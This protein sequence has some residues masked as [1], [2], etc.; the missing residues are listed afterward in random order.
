MKKYLNDNY[1]INNL[2][3]H[4]ICD[5][6]SHKY[7]YHNT[8]D[9]LEKISGSSTKQPIDPCYDILTYF[10]NSLNK[11]KDNISNITDI[12]KYNDNVY[13]IE[14]NGG[15]GIPTIIKNI[16]NDSTPFKMAIEFFMKTNP[17]N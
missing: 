6:D 2:K 4:Y 7:L 12:Y 8:N 9:L 3:D 1:N 5:T 11:D 13:S 10:P 14:W 17:S 15:H 16:T